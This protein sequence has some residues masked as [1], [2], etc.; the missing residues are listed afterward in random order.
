L[1][2]TLAVLAGR[3]GA[4]GATDVDLVVADQGPV[5]DRLKVALNAAWVD[6]NL[7]NLRWADG[8][9]TS[10]PVPRCVVTLGL[11]SL[12]LAVAR[13]KD[14]PAWSQVPV[15][16]ALIPQAAYRSLVPQLPKGSSAVWLDQ[17][18]DRYMGLLRAAM[19]LR[20]RI[21]VLIGPGSQAQE[22]KLEAAAAARGLQLVQS[23]I[24]TPTQDIF[25]N[26]QFVLGA[27]DVFLVLP[28]PVLYTAN[29]L[30][31]IL[32]ASYRQR[33]PLISYAAAH[34]SAGATLAL[35]TP[36]ESVAVQVM[37][38]L[39]T[40][41]VQHALPVPEG[42]RDLAV[43]VNDQ[44]ARSLGLDLPAP[45]GLEAALRRSENRS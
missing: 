10:T 43:S 24:S 29:S 7:L 39:R 35:H 15:L 31:N 9:A 30:Q 2:T 16:A 12:Q 14:V 1:G 42:P 27:C 25:P 38:A 6:R 33:V 21:G 34:T 23:S 32:I 17:P 26:L 11:R 40:L 36:V 5:Y 22:S 28:D 45:A 44:V 13:A 18:V 19:P 8:V 20:H 4:L 3:V 41:V 37:A